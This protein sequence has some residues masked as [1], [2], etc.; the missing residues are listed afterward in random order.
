MEKLKKLKTYHDINNFLFNFRKWINNYSELISKKSATTEYH[1]ENDTFLSLCTFFNKFYSQHKTD[2]ELNKIM[3]QIQYP[4]LSKESIALINTTTALSFL[5]SHFSSWSDFNE[6]FN[7]LIFSNITNYDEEDKF[8]FRFHKGI[9]NLNPLDLHNYIINFDLKIDPK[10]NWC[11]ERYEEYIETENIQNETDM[12]DL[13]EAW[14]V[15]LNVLQNFMVEMSDTLAVNTINTIVTTVH[16][17][18][19]ILGHSTFN[20]EFW[21]EVGKTRLLCQKNRDAMCLKENKNLEGTGKMAAIY[22]VLLYI[23]QLVPVEYPNREF[24][25]SCFLFMLNTGA[26][27]IT[28]CN[29]QLKDLKR[30]IRCENKKILLLVQAQVTK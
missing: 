17:Q 8:N 20:K 11:V 26:R 5:A 28:I 27:Y 13:I 6:Q 29:I 15:K 2:E 16:K 30:V 18:H 23:L 14:P 1:I 7:N 4:S 25:I 12:L 21:I 19:Q 10:T 22:I 3:K 24:F 9:R